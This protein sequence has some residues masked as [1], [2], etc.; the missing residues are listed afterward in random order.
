MTMNERIAA[1]PEIS[2]RIIQENFTFEDFKFEI[3]EIMA[4][5][6]PSYEGIPSIFLEVEQELQDEEAVYDIFRERLTLK[7]FYLFIVYGVNFNFLNAMLSVCPIALL[8]KRMETEVFAD[9]E[10]FQYVKEAFKEYKVN[11]GL[12]LS[13]V[14]KYMSTIDLKPLAEELQKSVGDLTNLANTK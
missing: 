10:M 14:M 11:N 4:N 3:L 1:L 13:T 6:K 8:D 5:K 7:M 2:P 12:T 9:D